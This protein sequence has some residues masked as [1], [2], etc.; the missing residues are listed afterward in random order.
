LNRERKEGNDETV[1]GCREGK[2][3]RGRDGIGE[4]GGIDG[5]EQNR[6]T[7]DGVFGDEFGDAL[8][9]DGGLEM[10]DG[11]DGNGTQFIC[12]EWWCTDLA[13]EQTGN[14][15]TVFDSPGADQSSN[16]AISLPR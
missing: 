12:R 7:R 10:L 1:K 11:E 2:R 8:T 5:V 4:K 6:M 3:E 9:R 15:P 13:G 14:M 16:S